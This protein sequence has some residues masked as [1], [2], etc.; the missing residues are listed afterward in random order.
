M[1]NSQEFKVDF[2]VPGFSKCGTTTLCE[3][4]GQH[5]QIFMPEG[6]NKEP[7]YFMREDYQVQY[8]LYRKIFAD[9]QPQQ[10]IGEGTT[11]YSA[12]QYDSTVC[13]RILEHNPD[14]KFI[15]IARD[16]IKRIESSYREFHNSGYK[17]GVNTPYTLKEAMQQLP[18]F[19]EDTRYWTRLN[20]FRKL[21]PDDRL[22]IVLLEDLM[23]NPIE[24]TQR[25]FAFLGVDKDF[26]IPTPDKKL[27]DA[28]EKYYDTRLLRWLRNWPRTA[29]RIAKTPPMRQ[30]PFFRRLGLRKP[31]VA[32]VEWGSGVK[33]ETIA[34]LK[35]DIEKFLEHAA[36]D[37]A[38]WK[39]FYSDNKN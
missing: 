17:F 30:E 8:D 15:F 20:S 19:I 16:P 37:P 32:P 35:P 39:H 21:I 6:A 36:A 13:A 31:F 12:Y 9:A 25:C 29:Y 5:P 34:K 3:L 38:R 7:M 28:G 11:F 22:L 23:K 4:L 18:A 2:M 24:V 10:L 27:N 33:E 26:V 14:I 1:N